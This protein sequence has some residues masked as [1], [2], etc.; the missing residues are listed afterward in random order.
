MSLGGNVCVGERSAICIGASVKHGLDIG[1]D[2]VV[3]GG[4]YVAKDVQG[5]SIYY[6]VPAKFI[7]QR[8]SS[9]KYL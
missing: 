5:S 8:T 4:S 3:G 6:G 1:D 2:A 9:D 7:K